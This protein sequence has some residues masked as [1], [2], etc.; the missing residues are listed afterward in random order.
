MARTQAFTVPRPDFEL[1]VRAY[2]PEAAEAPALPVIVYFHGGGFVVGSVDIF[3][4]LARSLAQATGAVV[5]SVDYRLAP[6]HPYPTP[7]GLRRGPGL[8]RGAGRAPRGRRHARGPGRRQRR[9][10]ARGSAGPARPRPGRA[11]IAA[12]LLYYPATDLSERRSESFERFIDGYGLSSEAGRAFEQAYVGQVEDKRQ[13][14]VSPL[15]AERLAGLPP[16]LV[17]TAGFDPLRDEGRA[18]AQRLAAEGVAV[19]HLEYPEMIHGFMSVV[20]FS[21]RRAALE[22]TGAFLERQLGR[23][24]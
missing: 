16:A 19:Q 23:A 14:Y 2:W 9:R 3:D 7:G 13:P 11:P 17:V 20:F 8:G 5:V 15:Y 22:Q 6:A 24:Q 18:Y 12:Q 10:A 1:P 21:Q 4:A